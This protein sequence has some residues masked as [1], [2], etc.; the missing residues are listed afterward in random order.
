[1]VRKYGRDLERSSTQNKT[2]F[3]YQFL[4]SQKLS[5]NTRKLHK[6]FSVLVKESESRN[7]ILTTLIYSNTLKVTIRPLNLH[8]V[9][10]NLVILNYF[11]INLKPNLIFKRDNGY[12]PNLS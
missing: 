9:K 7:K 6:M 12:E 1:M 11:C 4:I 3:R 2:K 5:S 8:F 10:I